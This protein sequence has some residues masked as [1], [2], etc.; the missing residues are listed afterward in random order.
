MPWQETLRM[1]Q[2]VQFI[3][4]YQRD[5]FDVTELAR[6]YDISRKT[7]YKWID[8]SG[9]FGRPGRSSARNLPTAPTLQTSLPV[10]LR[11]PQVSQRGSHRGLETT[12]P[13][14]T[15]GR[16]D[17]WLERRSRT[18]ARRWLSRS[19]CQAPRPDSARLASEHQ[20]IRSWYGWRDA[21]HRHRNRSAAGLQGVSHLPG[22]APRRS[23][24]TPPGLSHSG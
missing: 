17:H 23:C 24:R 4:D 15:H 21:L 8:R 2:R 16:S 19:R 13:A 9:V 20:P 3:A 10:T 14:Q 1:D 12:R 22:K 7:A 11:A 6:R 18:G 5:V